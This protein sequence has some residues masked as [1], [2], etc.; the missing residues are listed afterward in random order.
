MGDNLNYSNCG[1]FL[2]NFEKLAWA[3]EDCSEFV[4]QIQIVP[5]LYMFYLELSYLQGSC[6]FHWVEGRGF[7]TLFPICIFSSVLFLA[8]FMIKLLFSNCLLFH[9]QHVFSL[10]CSTQNHLE[11]V[12]LHKIHLT[13]C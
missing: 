8:P 3:I 7:Y 5:S 12:L 6:Y 2:Y 4:D 1:L 13:T 9:G 11:N 10:P